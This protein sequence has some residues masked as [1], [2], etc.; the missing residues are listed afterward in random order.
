MTG[1]RSVPAVA[2]RE[3]RFAP[4]AR[5]RGGVLPS[6]VMAKPSSDALHRI[7]IETDRRLGDVVEAGLERL[8]LD[9]AAWR[10]EERDRTSFDLYLPDRPAATRRAAALRRQLRAWAEG[11]PWRVSVAALPNEDWRESW[12]RFFHAKRV[13]A[14]IV[15]KPSWEPWAATAE[16]RIV[17]LDP[18]M[19]FGT[20]LHPTTRACLILLDDLAREAPGRSFLDVGCGSGILAIAAAKL[21]YAPVAALDCD[22]DAVRIARENVARNGVANR[23]AVR[24]ADVSKPEGVGVHD[25]VAANLLADLLVSQAGRVCARVRRGARGRLIVAG[26]LNAQYAAVRAA[27]E[28]R[29]FVEVR[30]IEEDGWTSGLFRRAEK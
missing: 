7:R 11:E 19:S 2:G 28:A 6:A 13:S 22:A 15:V 26:I 21:G 5:D 27:Y 14:R 23:V 9:F 29:G 4:L 24:I 3:P 1:S 18:G 10:E 30:A 20:G 16:D 17:E 12:K 8:G 25:V